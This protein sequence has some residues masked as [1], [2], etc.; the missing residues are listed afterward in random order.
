LA[1]TCPLIVGVV[2]CGTTAVIVF[3]LVVDLLTAVLDPRIR[4][5]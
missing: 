4:I 1:S 3:N 5:A 2:V